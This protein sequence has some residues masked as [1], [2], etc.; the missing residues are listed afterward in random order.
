MD[1]GKLGVINFNNMIPVNKN[2][3]NIIDLNEKTNDKNKSARIL[4]L[5]NQLRCLNNNRLHVYK[6]SCS[7]YKKYINNLLPINVRNRC[8]NFILLEEKCR[9]YNI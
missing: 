9:E 6:K 7:L 2:N 4:L 3:Y 8:C 1:N 5:K